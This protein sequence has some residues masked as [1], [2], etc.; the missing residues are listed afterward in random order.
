M[1]NTNTSSK[2]RLSVSARKTGMT[3]SP[4][5]IKPKKTTATN[6]FDHFDQTKLP[7][8]P[9]KSSNESPPPKTG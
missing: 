3:P 2:R 4:K 7:R 1:V 8:I 6:L 5:S 9:K